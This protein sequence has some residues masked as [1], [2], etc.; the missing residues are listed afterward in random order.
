[1]P[2]APRR[3]TGPYLQ[4]VTAHYLERYSSNRAHLARL[5]DRRVERSARHHAADPAEL[6]ALR[7]EGRA[8]VREELDRLEQI[9]LIDDDR[10]A[11][12]RAAAMHRRGASA[13][14]IRAALAARGLPSEVVDAALDALADDEADPELRAAATY[15]RKRGLGPWRRA[16]DTDE[17]RRKE[18]GRLARAGFPFALARRVVD[19]PSPEDLADGG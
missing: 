4:R 8:L 7:E 18:L 1:M 5:L 9:G 11:A 16:P 15:A 13:R 6:D 12:D 19:A 14:R 10:F 2:R 3:I 17:R